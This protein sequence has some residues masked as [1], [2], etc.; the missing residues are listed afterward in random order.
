[1]LA[2]DMQKSGWNVS[3]ELPLP[4]DTIVGELHGIGMGRCSQELQDKVACAVWDAG[5]IWGKTP[6]PPTA[7]YPATAPTSFTPTPRR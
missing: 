2:F 6:W 5:R 7:G 3:L 4:I 1:M